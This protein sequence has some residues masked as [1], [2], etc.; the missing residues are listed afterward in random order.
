MNGKKIACVVLLLILAGM[1]Y[2]TQ[3]MQKRS[4]AMNEEAEMAETDAKMAEGQREVVSTGLK[5]LEFESQ[6]LRQFLKDWEPLIRRVQTSQEADQALQSLLRNSGI[7]TM[8]QKFELKDAKDGKMFSKILQGTLVVQDEYAKT[9]NWL[10]ELERKLPFARVTV[11]RLK[12]GETGRQI[13]LELHFEV[14]IINLEAK[15]EET[16][17]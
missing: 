1:A 10:G 13:N 8:S 17:K 3:I 15:Q 9:L 16:K 6:D 2:G 4:K 7:L 11:C 14:P 5:A 12:Q